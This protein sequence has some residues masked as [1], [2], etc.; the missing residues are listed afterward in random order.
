MSRISRPSSS[1]MSATRG[2]SA[3]RLE[4]LLSCPVLGTSRVCMATLKPLGEL[5]ISPLADLGDSLLVDARRDHGCMGLLDTLRAARRLGEIASAPAAVSVASPWAGPSHLEG[6][7]W[8]DLL[9]T[10]HRG[11]VTR[12]DAMAIPAVVRGRGL[13]VTTIARSPIRAIRD[14]ELLA[15]Q[16]RWIERTSGP[17]SA[18]HRMLWTADDLLFY[19]WSLWAVT[20]DYDGRVIDAQ[21]VPITSW[22]FSEAGTVMIGDEVARDD[23]VILIPGVHEGI[24]SFGGETIRQARGLLATAARTA[25]NPSAMIELSQTNDA[26]MTREQVDELIARWAAARRGENGG[27][28]YTSPGIETKEHGAA[29]EHLLIEGR[30]ASAIDIARLLGIPSSMIDATQAGSS[31]SYSNTESRMS[32][33][34]EFGIAPLM[35]SIVSRLALD[36]VTPRGTALKFD[37]A[38]IVRTIAGDAAEHSDHSPAPATPSTDEGDNAAI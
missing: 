25:E 38:E 32:E 34:I 14:G 10:E 26:P 4:P 24:L 13:I 20:R 8:A 17:V 2:E 37:T 33:L 12:A 22:S 7:V 30:A 1:V 27:V 23:E 11:P 16:P 28:A 19:G 21:R 18:F 5:P 31:L 29:K 6:I 9:G 3:G 35:A 36:D 15:D